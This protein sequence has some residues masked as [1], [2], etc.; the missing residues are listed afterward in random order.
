MVTDWNVYN[1]NRYPLSWA[2][3]AGDTVPPTFAIDR[4]RGNMSVLPPGEPTRCDAG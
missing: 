1:R 3:V 2:I 4:T